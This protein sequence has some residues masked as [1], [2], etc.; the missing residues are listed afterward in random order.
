MKLDAAGKPTNASK[1]PLKRYDSE[2]AAL[3]RVDSLK[4]YGIWPGVVRYRD[5]RFGLT[6]DPAPA[7]VDHRRITA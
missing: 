4:V 7:L 6:Y 1:Y 5:G 2:K 3:D